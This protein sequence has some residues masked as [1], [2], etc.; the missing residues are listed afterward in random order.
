MNAWCTPY[1]LHDSVEISVEIA[2]LGKARGRDGQPRCNDVV[3]VESDT[4]AL[5]ENREVLYQQEGAGE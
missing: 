3:G 5:L 2:G 1:T 4:D